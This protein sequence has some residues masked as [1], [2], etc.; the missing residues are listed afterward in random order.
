[1]PGTGGNC[2]KSAVELTK[3]AESVGADGA[4]IV[5]PY[6]NKTT[7]DGLFAHYKEIASKTNLPIILYNV[8][9]RT[10]V[11]I[12][13][14]TCK[15]LAQI[16]NIVA[17]KEASG[18]ISQIAEI[19]SACGDSLQIYS[20]NDDQ[21]VPIL[22]LGGIGVISVISNIAPKFTHNMAK[23]FLDGSIETATNAQIKCIPLLKALFCEVNPIPVKAGLNMMGYDVG[24][25]RLPL[26]EMTTA[27]KDR[28]HS[29]LLA[30]NLIK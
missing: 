21:I 5:T 17:I 27:G 26:V 30:F 1:L 18:D 16:E 7:Q 19:A 4:L 23:D 6:Y 9:S 12:L 8:P 29:E 10:G 3:Y 11:N 25:P 2:T 14:A 20:G 22:A 28:L 24:I 15:K 13:P